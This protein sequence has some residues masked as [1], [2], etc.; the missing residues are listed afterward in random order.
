MSVIEHR[1]DTAMLGRLVPRLA[2]E[3]LEQVATSSQIQRQWANLRKL[4]DRFKRHVEHAI[5]CRGVVTFVDLSDE[6]HEVAVKFVSYAL[7]PESVYAV[8]LTRA[9][10][11]LKISVG[12]NP[13]TSHPR[14]HDIST[15][16]RRYGGG[17]HAVVGAIA[18]PPSD[19]QAARS[20]C[21]AIIDELNGPPSH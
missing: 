2:S 6:V 16:C 4:H 20:A 17:G 11:K 5:T 1:G 8:M 21:G 15:I 12:Y 18:L 9:R 10:N 14:L 3:P 13:W 19:L 7:H